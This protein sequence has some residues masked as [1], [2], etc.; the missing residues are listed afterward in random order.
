VSSSWSFIRQLEVEHVYCHCLLLPFLKQ[1][2]QIE[3]IT[4]GGSVKWGDE[5]G[6]YIRDRGSN[7]RL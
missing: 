4:Q 5:G 3:G 1:Y 2:I 7:R 6:I